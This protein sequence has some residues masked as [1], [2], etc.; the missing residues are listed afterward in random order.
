MW[1]RRACVEN[2]RQSLAH[3][4]A[5]ARTLAM[6]QERREKPLQEE[7]ARKPLIPSARSPFFN[8]C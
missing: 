7:L 3:K 5:S 1:N 2:P 4:Y 6:R 8:G